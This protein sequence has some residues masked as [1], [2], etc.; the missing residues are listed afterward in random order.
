MGNNL[1]AAQ[2]RMARAGLGW[3]IRELAARAKVHFNTV[4]RIERAL[5]ASDDT[6]SAIRRVLEAKGIEFLPDDGAG[7]GVRLKRPA[8]RKRAG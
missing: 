8:A 7:E 2:I 1:T 5:E 6:L 3:S 4:S